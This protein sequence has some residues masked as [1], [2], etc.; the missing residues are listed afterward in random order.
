ML[1]HF[2][3]A[4]AVPAR[5]AVYAHLFEEGGYTA[6]YLTRCSLFTLSSGLGLAVILETFLR[7]VLRSS[8]RWCLPFPAGRTGSAPRISFPFMLVVAFDLDDLQQCGGLHVL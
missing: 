7:M 8:S 1:N 3:S 4:A 5:T 6:V 2:L